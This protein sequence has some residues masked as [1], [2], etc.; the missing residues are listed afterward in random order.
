M[1]VGTMELKALV[2][3]RFRGTILLKNQIANWPGI[4]TIGGI[5]LAK[6][7]GRMRWNTAFK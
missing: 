6:N 5:A 3:P 4:K 1:Y 2:I 7:V